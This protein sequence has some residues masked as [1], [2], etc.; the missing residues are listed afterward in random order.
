[1]PPPVAREILK[2]P[3][4]TYNFS[5]FQSHI[6]YCTLNLNAKASIEYACYSYEVCCLQGCCAGYSLRTVQSWQYW[7][8][9]I[10]CI[11]FIYFVSQ[12]CIGADKRRNREVQRVSY[13]NRRCCPVQNVVPLHPPVVRNEVENVN[14]DQ[15]LEHL[16]QEYRTNCPVDNQGNA[17]QFPKPSSPPC[18]DEALYMPKPH[19]NNMETTSTSEDVILQNLNDQTEE[20][21][22]SYENAVH[23]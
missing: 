17:L 16:I 1:M 23:R 21:L 18:Y 15:F 9:I 11:V 14:V 12:Y 3:S 10:F 8:P 19:K 20:A 13:L 5:K 6:K 7:S 22:P 4:N 2:N